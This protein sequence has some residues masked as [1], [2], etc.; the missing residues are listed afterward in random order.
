MTEAGLPSIKQIAALKK[1]QLS[2]LENVI[3]FFEISANQQYLVKRIRGIN[4]FIYNVK[5]SQYFSILQISQ[6]ADVLENSIGILANHT[7]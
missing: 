1:P 2:S 5:E 4:D 7:I 6:K 3:P